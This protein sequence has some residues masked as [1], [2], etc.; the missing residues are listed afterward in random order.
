MK[1]WKNILKNEKVANQKPENL[2]SL[3]NLGNIIPSF[4]MSEFPISSESK[5]RKLRLKKLG[6][7]FWDFRVL[8]PAI[9]SLFTTTG[10][11]LISVLKNVAIFTGNHLCKSLFLITFQAFSPATLL[12]RDSNTGVFLLILRDF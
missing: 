11:L 2:G 3:G 4:F 6:K 5:N 12:K 10:M 1:K 8:D 7:N 9:T